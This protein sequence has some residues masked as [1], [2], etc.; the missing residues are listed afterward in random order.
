MTI[1]PGIVGC[2]ACSGADHFESACPEKAHPEEGATNRKAHEARIEKYV[3][4]LIYDDPPRI[5]PYQKQQLI[6]Q[7]NKRYRDAIA[8]ERKSA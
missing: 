6:K 3:A 2:F 5:N 8:K 7:E 1:V 4:W